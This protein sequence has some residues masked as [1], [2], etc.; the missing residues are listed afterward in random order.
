MLGRVIAPPPGPPWDL[1]VDQ[2]PLAFVDL[3]MTGLNPAVDRVVELCVECVVGSREVSSLHTLLD[4]GVPMGTSADV[5]GIEAGDLTGAP[6]FGTIAPE[7]VALLD[8]SVLVAHGASWDVHFLEAE[9]ERTGHPL[10]LEFW[11]DTLVLARRAFAF[12]SYGLNALCSELG[13]FRGRAHRADSDVHAMRAVFAKCLE[14]LR[15][16]TVRDLLDVRVGER[17]ARA[18]IVEAC[19]AASKG[20]VPLLITYRAVGRRADSFSMIV[21]EVRSDLDPPRIVGYQLPGRGRRELRADRI[22]RVEPMA[23]PE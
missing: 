3:E 21:L 13:I 15:P 14:A 11:I 9:A 5:H 8:G 23:L 4:P 1:P 18:A 2:A 10:K 20:R 19:G 22:L 12:R 7:L 17:H 6:S 16:T